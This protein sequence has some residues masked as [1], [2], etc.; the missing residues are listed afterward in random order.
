LSVVPRIDRVTVQYGDDR[1]VVLAWASRDLLLHRLQR[2]PAAVLLV[3]EFVDCGASTPVVLSA[4]QA[5]VLR[6][7]VDRWAVE[8]GGVEALP[9]DVRRVRRL[10]AGV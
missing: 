1:S 6:D 4:F 8:A 9:L 3:R 10:V 2:V 7:V 5:S